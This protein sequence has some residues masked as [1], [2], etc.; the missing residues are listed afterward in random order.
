MPRADALVADHTQDVVGAHPKFQDKLICIEL[1]GR[2]PFQIHIG[3]DLTVELFA[4]PM[5]MIKSNDIMVR[6]LRIYIPH[7]YFY[8]CWEEILSMLVDAAF[9]YLIHGTDSEWMLFPV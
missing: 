5:R 9:G 1:S 8:I 3:F 4:F 7:V 6:K 2:K